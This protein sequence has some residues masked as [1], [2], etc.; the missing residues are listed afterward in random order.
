MSRRSDSASLPQG[1]GRLTADEARRL[2]GTLPADDARRLDRVLAADPERA[3]RLRRDR[4]ALD[5]W[6]DE[7]RAEASGRVDHLAERVLARIESGGPT[8]RRELRGAIGEV[9]APRVALGYAAAALVLI[10]V[11][12]VGT[13]V[14]RHD[15]AEAVLPP[16]GTS[17]T[18]AEADPD[19]PLLDGVRN[20]VQRGMLRRPAPVH[21]SDPIPAAAP[22]EA[23][24]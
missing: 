24:R 2:D 3:R 14:L 5:L 23:G 21:E 7:T 9:L 20:A 16:S 8:R 22:E 6:I 1:L 18:G 10:G 11:G 4:A 19:L 15:R 17:P 13:W 12:L